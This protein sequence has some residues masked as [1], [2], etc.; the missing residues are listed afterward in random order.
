MQIIIAIVMSIG[1]IWFLGWMLYTIFKPEK[2]FYGMY[3]VGSSYE[4]EDKGE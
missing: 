2:R 3:E 4:K 1:L